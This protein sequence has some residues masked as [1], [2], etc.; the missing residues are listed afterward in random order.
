MRRRVFLVD[1]T[2]L[3]REL[4]GELIELQPD[5]ALAGT[6]ASGE[7]ALTVFP[8]VACDLA[9][10]DVSMPG[11]NGIDLVA[12][13]RELRPDFPC[14]LFSAHTGEVYARR[15]REVGA[16]GYVEKGDAALLLSTIREALEAAG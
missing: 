5:L 9:L 8:D 3:M 10:V 7:E 4:F 15:A 11:M 13:L 2:P 1:D 14:V 6:A 12:R 16:A